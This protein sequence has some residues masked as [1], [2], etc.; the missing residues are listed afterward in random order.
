[1]VDKVTN[2]G[3]SAL[4]ILFMFPLFCKWFVKQPKASLETT[5]EMKVAKVFH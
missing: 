3:R 4:R 1:M 5:I 2:I